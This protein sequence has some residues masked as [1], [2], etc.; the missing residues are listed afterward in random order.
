MKNHRG[1]CP[2]KCEKRSPTC[3]STCKT[4]LEFFEQNKQK[5]KATLFASELTDYKNNE[6]RRNKRHK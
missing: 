4:Y 1:P 5:Q 2:P 6:I 3:H